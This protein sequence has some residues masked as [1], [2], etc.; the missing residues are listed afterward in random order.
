MML[1]ANVLSGNV[2]V[3]QGRMTTKD[4]LNA[5]VISEELAN[6]NQLKVGDHLQFHAV[7]NEEPVQEATIVGIYQVKERMKP[8][9]SGDTF[10]SENVIFTDLHFPE[11]WSRMTRCMKRLI[12]RLR[13]LMIMML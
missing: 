12:L 2:S 1:D 5:C 9:M 8:Y 3:I 11:K 4:D 10:R 6:R 7:K 13:M